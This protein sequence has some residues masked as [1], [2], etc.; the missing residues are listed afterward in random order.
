MYV[1][2][3]D[4]NRI[5]K[6]D[7]SGKLL[8][9]FGTYGKGDGQ[10][11]SPYDI[12]I[13]RLNNIYV[14]DTGNRRIQKFAQVATCTKEK[15]VITSISPVSGTT[16]TMVTLSGSGFKPT[17][18]VLIGDNITESTPVNVSPDGHLLAFIFPQ[19]ALTISSTETYTLR[20]SNVGN[21]SIASGLASNSVLFNVSN[22]K[23]SI[24]VLSPNGGEVY[25]LGQYLYPKPFIKYDVK[26]A[27]ENSW[28]ALSL[29]KNGVGL[30]YITLGADT[31][32]PTGID[33][34]VGSYVDYIGGPIHRAVVGSD[35]T[36]EAMLFT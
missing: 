24:T 1:V 13:D 23:P 11:Y 3:S 36:I 33:W 17:S 7:A 28:V 8:M 21:V 16:G 26:N 15:P 6:F 2:D 14:V 20:V 18:T 27:P 31:S 32:I 29:Y 19:A 22:Q 12:M 30:G 4:N 9:K 25:Q 5:Q 35:Y 34:D 10:F